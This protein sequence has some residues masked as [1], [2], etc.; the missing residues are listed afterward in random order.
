MKPNQVQ[1]GTDSLVRRAI[2]G[3]ICASNDE[4]DRFGFKRPFWADASEEAKG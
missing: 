1:N 4:M 3:R 2:L